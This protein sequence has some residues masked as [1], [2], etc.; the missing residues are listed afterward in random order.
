MKP[1][2]AALALLFSPLLLAQPSLHGDLPL[3]YLEQPGN[4]QPDQP[5]VI[6]LHGYGSNQADLFSLKD[7]LPQGY[8][9]LSVRAPMQISQD[10]YQ[11]FTPNRQAPEYDGLGG[12]VNSSEARIV[13]FIEAAVAKYHTQPARVTL[14][15]FSQGAIMSYQVALHHPQ[16][17]GAIA[18]LSGKLLPPL[19]AKLLADPQYARLRFFIGHGTADNVLPVGGATQADEALRAIG[20]EPQIHLY[21]GLRHSISEAEVTDLR[22]WLQAQ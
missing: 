13:A 10:G 1:L 11:W 2:I 16:S 5:L 9:Y 14:V 15:G 4:G 19:R 18:A 3:Q 6:L 7:D 21:T 12:D 8:T 17:I 20:L 22:N